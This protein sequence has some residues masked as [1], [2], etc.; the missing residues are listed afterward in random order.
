MD[1]DESPRSKDNAENNLDVYESPWSKDDAENNLNVDEPPRS[2]DE[3][4]TEI[5]LIVDE[6]PR[7]KDDAKHLELDEPVENTSLVEHINP[8]IPA[9]WRQ[10]PWKLIERNKPLKIQLKKLRNSIGG[11]AL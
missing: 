4:E 9:M 10:P 6:S 5:D 8:H 11:S 7:S 3:T 2:K 1:V